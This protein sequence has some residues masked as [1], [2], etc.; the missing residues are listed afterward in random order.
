MGALASIAAFLLEHADLIGELANA[1]AGGA[2]KDDL[3]KAIRA[4]MVAASDAEMKKE[5]APPAPG[6]AP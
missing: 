5:L 6:V 4:S 3:R 2:S 1:L